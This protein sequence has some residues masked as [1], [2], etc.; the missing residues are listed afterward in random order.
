MSIFE[1]VMPYGAVAIVVALILWAQFRGYPASDV[2]R[3]D[4]IEFS[5]GDSNAQAIDTKHRDGKH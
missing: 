3:A 5:R 4:L 1:T 2:D